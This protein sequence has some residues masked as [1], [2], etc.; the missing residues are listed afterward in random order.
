M[1]VSISMT[2]KTA[3]DAI[4]VPAGA[5]FKSEEAGDYVLLAGSDAKAHQK[6]IQIG[7][8]SGDSAQVL[9]GINAGDPVITSGGYAVPDGTK[10]EIEKP[11]ADEK[12]GGA[13]SD[14]ADDEKAPAGE[15]KSSKNAKPPAAANSKKGKE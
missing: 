11:S 10:I 7:I 14:K 9:G 13:N 1:T 4:V 6:K 3:D 15:K 5:I 12:E 8:R 2:A